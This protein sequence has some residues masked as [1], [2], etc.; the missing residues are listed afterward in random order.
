MTASLANAFALACFGMFRSFHAGRG[1][2]FIWLV[3]GLG[4]IALLA[5]IY[6]W[7]GKRPSA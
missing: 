6:R 1:N 4:I 5:V 3:I 7:V 2:G